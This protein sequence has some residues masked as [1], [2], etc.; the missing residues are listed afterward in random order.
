M[1]QPAKRQEA[2]VPAAGAGHESKGQAVATRL[3]FT[4][5]QLPPPKEAPGSAAAGPKLL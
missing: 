4:C 3:S 5:L 1:R 2:A